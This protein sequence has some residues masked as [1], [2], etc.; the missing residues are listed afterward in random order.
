MRS[1]SAPAHSGRCRSMG[2][3]GR[4]TRLIAGALLLGV[5]YARWSAAGSVASGVLVLLV[6]LVLLPLGTTA[7]MRAAARGREKVDWHGPSAV[8]AQSAVIA[9]ALA[10]Q[11]WISGSL[12]VFLG[13]SLVLAS[14]RGYTGCEIL[15]YSNLLLSRRDEMGCVVFS[16]LDRLDAVIRRSA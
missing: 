16:P 7:L 6:G 14:V 8:L 5:A 2:M 12:L 15:A 11:G 4:A 3:V 13:A 1:D 10:G 9:G